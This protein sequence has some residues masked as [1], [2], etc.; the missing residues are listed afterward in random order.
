[1]HRRHCRR[2]K[3]RSNR[4]PRQLPAAIWCTDGRPDPLPGR[5]WPQTRPEP[6]SARR[7]AGGDFRLFWVEGARG[8]FVSD[9]V[10]EVINSGDAALLFNG[11]VGK[12]RLLEPC[13]V[14]TV[15]IRRASLATAM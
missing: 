4:K 8:H 7:D 15:R 10:D 3:N 1:M 12:V 14:S 11:V 2:R 13:Q 6:R 9:G 5:W